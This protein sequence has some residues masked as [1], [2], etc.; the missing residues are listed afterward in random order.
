MGSI[1]KAGLAAVAAFAAIAV[2]ALVLL[3]GAGAGAYVVHARFID[4]GQLVV[5][6]PV[7]VTG[8][9]LGKVTRLAVTPDG[10]ADVVLEIRSAE[11][12]PLHQGTLATIRTPGFSGVANRYVDISPGPIKAP[13]IPNGGVIDAEH[14]RPIVDLDEVLDMFDAKTRD[15][16]R[17][18]ISAGSEIYA[19]NNVR[20]VNR[21]LLYLNPALAQVGSLSQELVRDRAAFRR[22]IVDGS[23][24]VAALA[25]RTTDIEQGVANTAITL[26]AVASRRSAFDD[27]LSRTPAVFD[28]AQGSLRTIRNTLARVRPALREARPLAKPS[29]QLFRHFKPTAKRLM[30]VVKDGRE[31]LPP[32][33]ETLK[34]LPQLSRVGTP[35]LTSTGKAIQRAQPVFEGLR[36]YAP[37]VAAGL[38]GGLGAATMGAYDANGHYART[39]LTVPGNSGIFAPLLQPHLPPLRD[40]R[41]GLDARCAGGAAGPARDGSNPYV[42]DPHSCDPKDDPPR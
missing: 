1:S 7:E 35:A 38:F 2:I 8:E 24:V 10:Q 40:T 36:P 5:G 18:F 42:A 34:K 12:A 19:G 31:L 13:V 4:A 29:A 11:W 28:Q 23:T 17:G 32:L 16:L 41:S 14:T 26:R 21:T 39:Q 20:A 27:A 6:A 9:R 15:D 37:D 25:P 30:P 3:V 22:L 33:E